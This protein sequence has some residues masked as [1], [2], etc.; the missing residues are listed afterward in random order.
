MTTKKTDDVPKAP[1]TQVSNVRA[2]FTKEINDQIKKA[3]GGV[4]NEVTIGGQVFRREGAPKIA[5]PVRKPYKDPK[6]GKTTDEDVESV[7][8]NV[9]PHADRITLDGVI[10]LA[11]RSYEMPKAKADTVR[12]ICARTW[13]HEQQTGGANSYNTGVVRNPAHLN[14]RA[15]VGFMA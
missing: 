15:G 14:G 13:Q 8:I 5:G 7:T 1:E 9:A 4:L 11:N 2:Y 12:D 3:E 6:T 10:Y